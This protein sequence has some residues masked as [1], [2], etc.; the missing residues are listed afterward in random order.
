MPKDKYD[1]VI[2]LVEG[3]PSK[4]TTEH[5]DSYDHI[6]NFGDLY[7]NIKCENMQNSN[8][9][10]ND[11]NCYT[12]EFEAKN[13]ENKKENTVAKGSCIVF[14]NIEDPSTFK[15]TFYYLSDLSSDK[16]QEAIRNY[17][18]SLKKNPDVLTWD[19]LGKLGIATGKYVL[20][21][22]PGFGE[23]LD[24]YDTESEVL[25]IFIESEENKEYNK[26]I[27]EAIEDLCVDYSKQIQLS[28]AY[29]CLNGYSMSNIIVQCNEYGVVTDIKLTDNTV[30]PD[31]SFENEWNDF[32]DYCS[33]NNN[34]LYEEYKLIQADSFN[35]LPENVRNDMAYYYYRQKVSR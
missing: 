17:L 12:V 26:N 4:I 15:D 16:L 9:Y 2:R 32:L 8:K 3:L 23:A 21:F 6:I 22:V 31:F 5:L 29:F 1:L 11:L 34:N 30:S 20:S 35:E 19:N 7:F 28:Y 27:D 33:K 10:I 24:L 18:N 14:D 25:S 13:K